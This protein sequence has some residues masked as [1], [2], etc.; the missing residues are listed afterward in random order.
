MKILK[1]IIGD[2]ER[3]IIFNMSNNNTIL[4][5]IPYVNYIYKETSDN[6]FNQNNQNNNYNDENI[7]ILNNL[8][9]ILFIEKFKIIKNSL[10]INKKINIEFLNDNEEIY[11]NIC[12]KDIQYNFVLEGD[13]M[14][15]I[16]IIIRKMEDK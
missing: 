9:D 11:S 13:I 10:N 5:D 14:Y 8:N 2:Y 16:I 15:E 4:H 6:T 3:E 1:I 7:I 12:V